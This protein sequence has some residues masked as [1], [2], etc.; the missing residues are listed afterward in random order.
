MSERGVDTAM[1]TL[2]D[3]SFHVIAAVEERILEV[4]SVVNKKEERKVLKEK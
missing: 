4:L 1:Y 3:W 2:S